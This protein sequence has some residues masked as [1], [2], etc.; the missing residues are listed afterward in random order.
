MQSTLLPAT[1]RGWKMGCSFA[2]QSDVPILL[3]FHLIE[4]RGI[5]VKYLEDFSNMWI[6]ALCNQRNILTLAIFSFDLCCSYDVVFLLLCTIKPS[7]EKPCTLCLFSSLRTAKVKKNVWIFSKKFFNDADDSLGYFGIVR[8]LEMA[9]IGK[10]KPKDR[11]ERV[12]LLVKGYDVFYI[13][14]S[15]EMQTTR[16]FCYS[17]RRKQINVVD[18]ERIH[19]L[20]PFN[21]IIAR[22]CRFFFA[23]L[24]LGIPFIGFFLPSFFDFAA[25]SQQRKDILTCELSYRFISVHIIKLCFVFSFCKISANRL[26][27]QI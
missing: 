11:E 2:H 1:A 26:N 6:R 22:L 21:I 18:I 12:V 23:T 8:R 9:G 27:C 5:A 25:T 24:T 17:V 13:M 14:I 4:H 16:N 20:I 3:G 15:S 10:I 19:D 7:Q